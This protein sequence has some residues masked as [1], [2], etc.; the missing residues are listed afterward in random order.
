MDGLLIR[1]PWIGLILSGRKTWEMR[2]TGC[3]KRG[4]IALIR[5]GSGL[6]VGVAEIVGSLDPL[7]ALDAYA[8]G[9]PYHAIGPA[10]QRAA[11]EGNWRTPWVLRNALALKRP[12]PYRHPSGAVTWVTLDTMV[13]SA[14]EEQL[15]PLSQGGGPASALA[16]SSVT[17]ADF[18]AVV[19]GRSTHSA[20]F[21][22]AP[23]PAVGRPPAATL[24]DPA[25]SPPPAAPAELVSPKGGPSRTVRLTGGNIR[26]GHIY[27]PLDFFPGDTVGGSN[28][29]EAAP[30]RLTVSFE[31]GQ[32]VDTDIDSTKRILR[33]RAPVRDFFARAGLTE[34]DAVLIER[35]APYSYRFSKA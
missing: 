9:E 33:T 26:N 1:E 27:V 32:T 23:A 10:E 3:R 22:V 21:T 15:T 24:P 25:P 17:P 5:A 6:V 14:I 34:G 8:A 4:R 30:R 19:P 11:F 13:A 2:T 31:P 28:K 20:A 7:D 16:P 12:V 18:S 29:D 35:T